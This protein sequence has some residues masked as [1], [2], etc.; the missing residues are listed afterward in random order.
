MSVPYDKVA[1]TH[2]QQ[3]QQ[4]KA[5]GLKVENEAK[6]IHILENV[7]YYRLSGYWYPLLADKQNHTF[8]PGAT[9]QTAF[10][11]YCFD[12]ELRRLILS[13]LE[14]IEV[15]IRAQMIY[16]L[17]HTHGPFWYTNRV[18]FKNT[19]AH[20][21]SIT[22]IQEEFDRSDEQF[23]KA[24]KAKYNNPLP[25]SWMIME[26]TSFGTLSMLYKNLTPSKEKRDVAHYFGLDDRTFQSWLHTIVFLRNVC[27][28][29]SRLWNRVVSIPPKIPND[30]RNQ[31]IQNSG[32]SNDKTYFLLTMIIYL[33]E[34][35]NPK[36]KFRKRMKLLFRKY[37]IVDKQ[38]MGFP[39]DWKTEPLW[40]TR[41]REWI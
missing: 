3:L 13:E 34:I 40:K 23:I 14:K 35:V 29:H 25:P 30:P 18:L 9:F 33:L 36:H 41:L 31:W 22:K 32:V 11:L 24:F 27:A 8:K 4:L 7:S 19:I 5:R 10:K 38:A 17:S 12:R 37:A 21:Q 28:H 15:S 1:L 26:V 2:Q 16:I 20:S 6:A 39:I